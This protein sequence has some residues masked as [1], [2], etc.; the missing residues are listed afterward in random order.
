MF[1]PP[2]P[3]HKLFEE[4]VLDFDTPSSDR[5][6]SNFLMKNIPEEWM[7]NFDVDIVGVHDTIVVNLLNYKKIPKNVYNVL[8]GSYTP[9]KRYAFLEQQF[10]APC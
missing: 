3:G 1:N 4:L 6:K 2:L 10:I 7:V 9:A 5:R 8:L